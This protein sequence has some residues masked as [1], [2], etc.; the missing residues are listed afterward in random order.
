MNGMDLERKIMLI[1]DLDGVPEM[2]KD[3]YRGIM[4]LH[5]S[6]DGEVGNAQRKAIKKVSRD[7][8]EWKKII[9]EF[10]DLQHSSYPGHRIYA[11]VNSR[12]MSKAIHEFKA[13]QLA[14][15]YGN[16]YELHWFYTDIQN[17]FFSCLMNPNCRSQN[18]FLIDCDSQDEYEHAMRTIPEEYLLFAYATKNG[19]HILTRPFNPHDYKI[20]PKKDEMI[21]IG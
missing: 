21:F 8:D 7:P 14:H 10:R 6:K 20:D 16:L 3:G 18:S 1:D 4:L 9:L 12:D 13:R 19:H 2:F 15:D 17:R 5:R 11:S